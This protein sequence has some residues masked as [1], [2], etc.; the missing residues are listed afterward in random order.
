MNGRKINPNQPEVVH[1]TKNTIHKYHE[2]RPKTLK[3]KE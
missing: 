1:T 3:P 2:N